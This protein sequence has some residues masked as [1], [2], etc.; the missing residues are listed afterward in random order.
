MN[1]FVDDIIVQN[2][3]PVKHNQAVI[4]EILTVADCI[5]GSQK[6]LLGLVI[7]VYPEVT[8]ITEI[9]PNHLFLIPDNQQNVSDSI[10][11]Q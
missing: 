1:E 7:Y 3:V 10:I 11:S 9:F 8:A 5:G 4:D 2:D 6:V